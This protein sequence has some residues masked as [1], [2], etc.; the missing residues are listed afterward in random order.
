MNA[1]KKSCCRS[2]SIVRRERMLWE[3]RGGWKGGRDCRTIGS[4]TSSSAGRRG[5]CCVCSVSFGRMF[6]QVSQQQR[7]VTDGVSVICPNNRKRLTF[8]GQDVVGRECECSG[9]QNALMKALHSSGR[10]DTIAVG[11]NLLLDE[12]SIHVRDRSGL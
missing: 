5:S 4:P 11:S 6:V 10:P 8:V 12:G 7:K 2:G 3:R 1:R 9:G